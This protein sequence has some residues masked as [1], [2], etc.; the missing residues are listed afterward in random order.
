MMP[1]VRRSTLSLLGTTPK[2]TLQLNNKKLN[3]MLRK[4][5]LSIVCLI[6]T[7]ISLLAQETPEA[8][9]LVGVPSGWWEPKVDNY[10]IYQN[11][12]LLST[13]PGKYFLPA[14][15]FLTLEQD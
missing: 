5:F 1:L 15:V 11:Y 7:T 9:Y 6:M 8:C 14:P 13:T 2:Q 3:F 4:L 10:E 12:R